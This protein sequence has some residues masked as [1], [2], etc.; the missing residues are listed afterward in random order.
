MINH[1]FMLSSSQRDDEMNASVI[2]PLAGIMMPLVLAPTI[3]A[4][5]HRM[6]KREW[7]HKERLR[8]LELGLP[9]PED[10]PHVGGG[11]VAAIGA[12]VPAASVLAAWLT[13][14]TVPTSHSDFMGVVALAW[15]CAFMISMAAVIGS[16]VLASRLLSARR[17]ADLAGELAA[18]KPAYDPDA[19]DVV[20]SRG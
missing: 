1:G 14:A 9:V 10:R 8:A 19:Y 11:T 17:A 2:V 3:I 6:K 5:A 7:Q 16:L 18:A 15:G 13:T 4:M 12:G 20:S